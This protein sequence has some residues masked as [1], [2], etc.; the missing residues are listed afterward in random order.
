MSLA[1]ADLA[2]RIG[3]QHG[4]E[5]GIVEVP[6]EVERQAEVDGGAGVAALA[7]LHALLPGRAQLG[8][9]GEEGREGLRQAGRAGGLCRPLRYPR[10]QP[11]EGRGGVRDLGGRAL[12][13]LPGQ[14]EVAAGRVDLDRLVLTA[15]VAALWITRL[16]VRSSGSG[17]TRH[18]IF[19]PVPDGLTSA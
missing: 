19:T 13:V 18:R 12:E 11:R 7:Q 9:A 17:S 10:R 6:G 16:W 5:L 1:T 3:P 14:A 8:V 15:A 2:V 4:F